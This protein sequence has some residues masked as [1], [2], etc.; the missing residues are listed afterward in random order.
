MFMADPPSSRHEDENPDIS[1]EKL[2]L[3]SSASATISTLCRVR[4]WWNR[5]AGT[6]AVILAAL[7]P[8]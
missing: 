2:Q 7:M 3:S 8:S 4:D 5:R 6:V 1:D